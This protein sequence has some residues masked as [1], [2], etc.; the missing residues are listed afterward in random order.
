MSLSPEE[1]PEL[2]QGEELLTDPNE[3]LWRQ[4]HPQRISE[5]VIS[6]EA[7]E[8][9]RS[10]AKQLSCSRE[11]KVSAEEAYA[12]Y[13]LELRMQSAGV[14]AISVQDVESG[15]PIPGN[16]SAVAS[17]RAVDDTAS[18]G[19]DLPPGH[20]YVDFRPLGSARAA[21]KAKQL[22]FLAHKRGAI[23]FPRI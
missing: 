18:G 5:G 15:A 19:S 23:L 21:K 14:A 2:S 16:E 12:H 9:G 4:V 1:W 20:T 3:R 17:L 11:S 7:F 8:P 13:T 22:A 6:S 10:D